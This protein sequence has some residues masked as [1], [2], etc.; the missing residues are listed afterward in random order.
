MEGAYTTKRFE[1]TPDGSVELSGLAT[2]DSGYWKAAF[3][4][5]CLYD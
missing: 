5:E 4:F 3:C 2:M 1:G